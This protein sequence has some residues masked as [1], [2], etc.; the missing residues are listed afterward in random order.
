MLRAPNHELQSTKTSNDTQAPNLSHS[1]RFDILKGTTD[2]ESEYLKRLYKMNYVPSGFWSRLIARLMIA[3]QKWGVAEGLGDELI[4]SE[5]GKTV[6][7]TSN[8]RPVPHGYSMIYWREGM[9]VVYD[10]G[11]LMVESFRDKVKP[12]V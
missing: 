1:G 8:L 11:H 2:S 12:S 9:G 4:S 7:K 10:G 6:R 3:I 5:A